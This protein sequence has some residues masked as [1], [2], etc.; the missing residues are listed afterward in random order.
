MATPVTI[1]GIKAG[2][3]MIN[4]MKDIEAIIINDDDKIYCSK[5]IHFSQGAG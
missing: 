4:Q 5:N 1:M 2:L 3:F